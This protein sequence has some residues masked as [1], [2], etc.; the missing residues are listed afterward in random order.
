MRE[1]SPTVS[2]LCR[3]REHLCLFSS[4]IASSLANVAIQYWHGGMRH[5]RPL[6]HCEE[7]SDVTISTIHQNINNTD[8]FTTLALRSVWHKSGIA[9]H[10]PPSP[11]IA[12]IIISLLAIKSYS[13]ENNLKNITFITVYWY[14]IN[15]LCHYHMDCHASLHNDT[16]RLMA[17]QVYVLMTQ[18]FCVK[19]RQGVSLLGIIR[20]GIWRRRR[21]TNEVL[22]QKSVSENIKD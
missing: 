19:T 6:C 11:V 16:R 14:N 22:A 7:R 5:T 8:T 2:W 3:R 18:I 17:Y 12:F 10:T 9:P 4:V 13:I 21:T 20:T 1:R 15:F